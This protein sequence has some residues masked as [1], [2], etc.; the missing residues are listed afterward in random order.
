MRSFAYAWVLEVQLPPVFG[1]GIANR[2][3]TISSH[4]FP[5]G[6]DLYELSDAN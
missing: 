3:E 1:T 2:K 4:D 6:V 5:P